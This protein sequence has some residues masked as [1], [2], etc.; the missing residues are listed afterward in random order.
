M[1]KL[2]GLKPEKVFHFFEEISSIP[3]GSGDMEKIS[4]YC[5]EFAEKRGL[6]FIKDDDNNVV[7]FIILAIMI[8]KKIK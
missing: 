1:R 8:L 5:A 3:R 7:I 6:E 4:R 2:S